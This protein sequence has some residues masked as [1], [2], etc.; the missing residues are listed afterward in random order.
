[1]KKYI[2]FTVIVIITILSFVTM[3]NM[4]QSLKADNERLKNNQNV[5]LSQN[6]IYMAE[7]QKYRV[8]DSLYAARASELRLTLKEYEK[9]RSKDLELIKQLKANKSD[10]QKVVSSQLATINSLRA[11]LR[12]S[13]VI[14]TVTMEVD[15]LKCF[16]VNTKWTDISGHINTSTDSISVDIENR[17]SLKIVESV[18]YKRFW[19]FLWK[20]NKIKSRQVDVISEN[21]NTEIIS[22]EYI[23][24]EM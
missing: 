2:A 23:S 15:T 13:M 4:I 20:T 22:V 8:S 1:M 5:L 17:E 9:Y 18:T 11:Q 19:G 12:D 6:I 24:I 21:P 16:S 10:L 3:I 14:D 7:S